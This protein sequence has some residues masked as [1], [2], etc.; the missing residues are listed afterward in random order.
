MVACPLDS[1][2]DA[3]LE[4]LAQVSAYRGADDKLLFMLAEDAGVMSFVAASPIALAGTSWR[5]M[6]VNDGRQAV[7]SPIIGTT[8]TLN[9]GVDG[10]V[11]GSAGC[12]SYFG[13]YQTEGDQIRVGPLGSTRKMCVRPEGIMEQEAQF[14][15]A[16]QAGTTFRVTGDRLNIRNAVGATQISARL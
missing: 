10:Q 16:L 15:A 1:Q 4:E 6:G 7:T 12:N 14:L 2:A 9:F 8:V 5:V 3:F 11:T 13:P